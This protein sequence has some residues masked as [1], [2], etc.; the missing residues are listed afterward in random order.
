MKFRLPKITELFWSAGFGLPAVIFFAYAM[1]WSANIPWKDDY[2]IVLEFLN[3]FLGNGTLLHK[4][5]LLV[6]QT[7]EHRIILI[8][9]LALLQYLFFH[10]V[11]FKGLVFLGNLGYIVF[12]YLLV[13]LARKA[14]LSNWQVLPLPYILFSFTQY[15]NFAWAAAQVYYW[16]ALF[17]LLFIIALTRKNIFAV[18]G[19]YA[20]NL[21]IIAGG[22]ILFP[23]GALFLFMEKRWKDFLIFLAASAMITGLYFFRYSS[24]DVYPSTASIFMHLDRLAEYFFVFLGNASLSSR[25]GIPLGI[26]AFLLLGFILYHSHGRQKLLFLAVLWVLSTAA[27]VAISRNSLGVDQALR[28]RYA[29]YGLITWSCIFIGILDAANTQ[30]KTRAG[31]LIGQIMLIAAL[32]YFSLALV[33][34]E[35]SAFMPR[36]FDGKLSDLVTTINDPNSPNYSVLMASKKLGIFDYQNSLALRHPVLTRQGEPISNSDFLGHIDGMNNG[37][38]SG[39]ALI[40]GLKTEHSQAFILIKNSASYIIIPTYMLERPDVS[41]TYKAPFLYNYS[42]Y[43][44]YLN[45][46]SIPESNNQ[47]LGVMV[48]NGIYTAIQWQATPIIDIGK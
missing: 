16:S 47:V 1:R 15:E 9:V 38:I 35:V 11:N 40:P 24:P 25:L 18:I 28:S 26:I 29:M 43:E 20:L 44:A 19:L 33:R 42:G 6:E 46:Y 12:V 39:W 48:A 3:G 7:N 5:W 4:L 41:T 36:D 10:E 30:G 13:I 37:H 27:V 17:S 2:P 31:L 21:G 23:I 14:H 45:A 8:K 34:M 22:L 32:T